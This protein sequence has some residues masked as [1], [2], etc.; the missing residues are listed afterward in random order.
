MSKLKKTV[1]P[2]VR[3]SRKTCAIKVKPNGEVVIYAPYRMPLE[4]IDKFVLEKSEWIS[5]TRQS[6]LCAAEERQNIKK[7]SVDEIQYLIDDAKRIIP[8]RVE[9]FA[10]EMGVRYNRVTIKS[11]HTRWGSCSNKSNLNFNCLLLLAPENV[12]DYVVVHELCHLKEMNHSKSFWN[13][14]ERV[15][16][17]YKMSY[18]WLK[19]HGGELMAQLP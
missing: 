6:V 1:Y 17:D 5:K 9:H 15:L 13:E 3:S 19:K 4:L 14:V 12:L 16:P 8:L 7:L 11:Q 18:D 10:K 2:I